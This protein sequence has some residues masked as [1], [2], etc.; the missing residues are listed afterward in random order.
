MFPP[1][2]NRIERHSGGASQV[3]SRLCFWHLCRTWGQGLCPQHCLDDAEHG[4]VLLETVPNAWIAQEHL[5]KCSLSEGAHWQHVKG[6]G[7]P[8]LWQRQRGFDLYEA[9]Y[10]Q[11]YWYE[12]AADAANVF[13]PSKKAWRFTFPACRRPQPISAQAQLECLTILIRTNKTWHRRPPHFYMSSIIKN[14]LSVG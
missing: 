13:K 8:F 9:A 14:I 6:K 7:C 12:L 4:D 1:V 5:Y 11:K 10:A 2:S 3:R